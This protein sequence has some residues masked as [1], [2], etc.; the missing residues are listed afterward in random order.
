[1]N[2]ASGNSGESRTNKIVGWVVALAINAVFGVFV[3]LGGLIINAVIRDWRAGS[4]PAVEA[5]LVGCMGFVMAGI[6]AGFFYVAYI[7]T[8]RFLGG[9]E[10][11]RKKH[12]HQPWLVK[13]QWRARRLVHSTK[14]TAWFMWFWCFV[15][16]AIVGFLWSANKDLIMAELRGPWGS[17]IPAA[18]PFVAGTIGLLVAITLTW[19]RYRYGD[20]QFLLESL[21]GFLG[22][23]FRG[24]VQSKLGHRPHEPVGITL[25]CGNRTTKRVRG[26]DGKIRTIW[27]TD[28]LWSERKE[29][30]PVHMKLLK[31]V[32][33]IAV[34]IE[35]PPDLPESGH[36]LDDPQIVWMLKITPGSVLDRPLASEFEVPVFAR[37]E[38]APS[39]QRR[40][41]GGM[42]ASSP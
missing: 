5:L 17:A 42:N 40:E 18:M 10:R 12:R 6:G 30:H 19:Q 15:W 37:R 20:V 28:V 34:D 31:G 21:P 24:T 4:M 27:E 41:S 1:M 3:V 13:R 2:E 22:E 16:W 35:L 14:F 25:T 11:T 39:E 29:M 9:L 8:P 36:V 32:V 33:T 23:K 7:G 26:T 38:A